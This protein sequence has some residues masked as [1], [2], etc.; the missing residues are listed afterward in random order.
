MHP[1]NAFLKITVPLVL[2]GIVAGATMNF[3]TAMNELSSSLVLYVGRT[4]TMP[5]AIYLLVTDGEYGTASAL[6]TILLAV[7]AVLVYVAFRI[8]GNERSLM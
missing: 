3:V 8:T 1:A 7:T 2:P 6:A 4:V 5:I